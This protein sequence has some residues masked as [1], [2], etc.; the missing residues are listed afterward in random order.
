[1]EAV[2]L[3][4]NEPPSPVIVAGASKSRHAHC[5]GR[6]A[7]VYIVSHRPPS[8]CVV[9][10]RTLTAGSAVPTSQPRAGMLVKLIS[11]AVRQLG[12]A[13]CS[14]ARL[15]VQLKVT[16]SRATHTLLNSFAT[17]SILQYRDFAHSDYSGKDYER[18]FC[19]TRAPQAGVRRGLFLFRGGW[20][21]PL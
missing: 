3:G 9:T 6:V 11:Q 1:M 12:S 7:Y 20:V 2:I 5:H 4:R 15:V 10:S 14:A 16:R 13:I 18:A 19:P 17:V 21:D 8:L